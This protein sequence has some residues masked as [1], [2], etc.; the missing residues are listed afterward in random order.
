MYANLRGSGLLKWAA[1][2]ERN[3]KKLQLLEDD[4]VVFDEPG[5]V[6]VGDIQ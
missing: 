5:E 1:T 6:T 3:Q 4:D 2:Q